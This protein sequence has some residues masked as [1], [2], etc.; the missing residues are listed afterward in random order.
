M[1]DNE[2]AKAKKESIWT[3]EINLKDINIK[4][5]LIYTGVIGL[6]VVYIGVFIYPKFVEYRSSVAN[7][8]QIQEQ[9]TTYKNEIN[10]LPQLQEQLASL[11]EELEEKGQILSKNMEDGM[12]LVGLSNLMSD[13]NVEMVSYSVDDTIPF[14]TF[15]AI[16]TTIEVRGNYN[17]IRKI[18][19]YMEQQS[20]MTQILD[21]NMETYIEEPEE[22]TTT[23]TENTPEIVADSVVYWTKQGNVYHKKECSMLAEL[24]DG[25]YFYSGTAEES[26]K[27]DPCEICKPYTTTA[28]TTVDQNTE[29]SEPKAT[30][31]IVAKF[32]FIMYSSNNPETMNTG[33]DKYWKPGKYNPFT[34]TTR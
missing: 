10:N 17:H 28:S 19:N 5:V 31:K 25:E 21:Y 2:N 7:L 27:P 15:Y 32:K 18:M 8:E 30:G 4:D 14:N 13:L 23:E 33:E 6:F 20:N 3:K 16:P 24:G 22:T 11:N 1:L 26:K 12:F 34:T 9:V 29:T